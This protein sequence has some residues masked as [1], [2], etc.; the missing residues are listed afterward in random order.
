MTRCHL[1]AYFRS[2]SQKT[3]GSMGTGSLANRFSLP[4]RICRQSV[5]SNQAAPN[6]GNHLGLAVETV[7]RTLTRFQSAGLL[8]V[9]R[10]WVEILDARRLEAVAGLV[11]T[12]DTN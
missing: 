7:S 3:A 5:L 6:N 4:R 9:D 11:P 8:R 10:R 12:A 2:H 1:I